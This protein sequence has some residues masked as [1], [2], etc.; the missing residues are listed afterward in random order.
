[1]KKIIITIIAT[2]IESAIPVF[3]NLIANI[4]AA[5]MITAAIKRNRTPSH[6]N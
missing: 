3:A 6:A 2:S 4:A 5:T 1:M